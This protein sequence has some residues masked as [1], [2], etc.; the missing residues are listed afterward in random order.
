MACG[1]YFLETHGT[2]FHGKRVPAERIMYVVASLAEGLGI[3]AVARAFEVDPNT[4]L[5]WLIEAADHVAAFSQYFLHDIR[6]TQVQRD[7]LF[8][9]LSPPVCGGGRPARHHAAQTRGGLTPVA[10]LV[11][12]VL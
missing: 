8:A 3:R 6:V 9:L 4:V 1:G 7:E 11:S 12:R 2:L 5:H 10:G